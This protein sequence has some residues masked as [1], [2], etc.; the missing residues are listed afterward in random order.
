[1]SI[2]SNQFN[3]SVPAELGNLTNLVNLILSANNLTGE[4]PLELNN[5]KGLKEVR[6]SSNKFRG[7]LPSFHSWRELEELELQATG[8]EGPIP[9]TI[10][11]STNLNELRISDLNIGASKFPQLGGMLRMSKLMLRSCNISGKIPHYLAKFPLL[12]LLDLSFNRLEGEIPNLE[13]LLKLEN[14]YLTGNSLSGPIED[15]VK[16]RDPKHQ[17]DLSYNN[18][19]ESYVPHNC[20]DTLNLFRSYGGAKAKD[21][22]K[23]LHPCSKDY[24]SF[25]VNCGGATTTIGETVYKGDEGS[26]GAAK[27]TSSEENWGTS[28]TGASFDVNPALSVYV[29]KNVSVLRQT[30]SELYITAR[31]S[32]VSLTY[33]G[34]CLAN[35]KYNVTL[36]F[37]EIVFRDNQSFQSLGRRLFDVYIQGELKLKDFNIQ[38]E[39][40]GVD[41]VTLQSFKAIVENR[42]LEIR[43][44]YT[45]KGTTDIPHRGIYGPLVSAISV[46]SEFKPPNRKRKILIP[47]GA[48]LLGLFLVLAIICYCWWNNYIEGRISREKE[49]RGLDLRT[50]FFTL[51]QIKAATNNFDS[52][53]KIG[54]G[55]FGSVYK[56][57]LLDGS[58][59][60]V[61]Q[62]S[63]KSSQ[64]NR[65]FVT[66]IG[67]ISGLQHP[68]LV[69][70]YGCC[71]EGSQ[72][73]LVYEYMENNSLGRALFGPEECQLEMDW[74]MR[75]KICVGIAEGLAFLHEG[76]VLKIVHRDIKSNNILL[77]K[78]LNPKIADFGLAK[79]HDEDNTNINTRVAGTIGYMAPEYAL[80]GFL[81][82]KADVYSFG[83]VALEIVS[84]KNIMKYRPGDD[85][86]C[87]LDWALFL[88]KKGSL[89]ELVDPKLGSNFNIN[90]AD[91]MIR[92]ALLCTSPSPA[93]RPTMS[94]VVNMLQGNIRIQEFNMDPSIYESELKLQA[95]R[96]KYSDLYLDSSGSQAR[97]SSSL[98]MEI[99]SSS[100]SDQDTIFS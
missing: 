35:G 25:H 17:I 40:G 7:K 1:M 9:S 51:R 29:A 84:G 76:S 39:A 31:Q 54:E 13:F 66:E 95:F 63:S 91:K 2:E 20:R 47:T 24:Y 37:A 89:M 68:N 34:R 93:L 41:K 11:V 78:D 50:G 4:L 69:K 16:D 100:K 75:Q 57:T 36:H 61:K 14:M 86:A 8:F 92:V 71:I 65:E 38:Q 18:L 85:F 64:G 42:T 56:G 74:P 73:L 49:L 19:D 3:G 79:L 45:G 81:T 70:L 28:S 44:Q 72:L 12:K 94:E 26:S 55:G 87:L 23:C 77:D 48:A 22:A 21:L 90:E 98:A 43:F 59:I 97:A 80:W 99:D 15:W 53:N 10:S 5:L 83:V 67:L 58:I 46:E 52:A 27:F 32:P 96:E 82:N 6:L 60:A 88:Q 62:L 33:Y 30:N